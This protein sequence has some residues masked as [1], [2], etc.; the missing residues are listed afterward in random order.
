MQ[1]QASVDYKYRRVGLSK[2][3]NDSWT[4]QVRFK[5][6]AAIVQELMKKHRN[7]EFEIIELKWE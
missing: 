3:A 5:S 7:S 1:V 6:E 4:G 2:W